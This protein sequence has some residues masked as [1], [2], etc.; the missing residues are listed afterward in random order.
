[1]QCLRCFRLGDVICGDVRFHSLHSKNNHQISLFLNSVM[2]ILFKCAIPDY[3][4]AALMG[5]SAA[6]DRAIGWMNFILFFARF[7]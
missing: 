4:L 3:I 6:Y 2:G 7:F 5:L 1:M